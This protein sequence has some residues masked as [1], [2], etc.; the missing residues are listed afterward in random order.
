MKAINIK[1]SDELKR[2]IDAA[3]IEQHRSQKAV[4]TIALERYFAALD[5]EGAA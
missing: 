2:L 3:A 4:I 5:K 1:I